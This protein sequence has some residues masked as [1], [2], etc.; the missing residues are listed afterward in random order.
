MSA[1]FNGEPVG[2]A[3]PLPVGSGVICPGLLDGSAASAPGEPC[4][5]ALTDSSS[6]VAGVTS[7]G[8]DAAPLD[9]PLSPPLAD[10]DGRDPNGLG[11]EI[12]ALGG[13]SSSSSSLSS[14]SASRA[15]LPN[16][17]D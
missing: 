17:D 7:K 13:S 12:G 15:C 3:F 11:F 4:L 14:D 2:P 8:R 5:D 16:G 1:G 9:W 6:E 10:D